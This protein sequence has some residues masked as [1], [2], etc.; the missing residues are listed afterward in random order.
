MRK[1][2]PQRYHQLKIFDN[3]PKDSFGTYQSLF[4]T[5]HY[6]GS[7][8]LPKESTDVND[9]D[10]LPK[11]KPPK[12]QLK[13]ISAAFTGIW[14]NPAQINIYELLLWREKSIANCLI[15][16][17][18]SPLY[19]HIVN[20]RQQAINVIENKY[21]DIILEYLQTLCANSNKR[22]KIFCGNDL[23]MSF[24]KFAHKKSLEDNNLQSPQKP[25]SKDPKKSSAVKKLTR[26]YILNKMILG[27]S[28]TANNNVYKV[29]EF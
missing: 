5:Y 4:G 26:I 12:T 1:A 24:S 16:S 9:Q 3:D 7:Q 25:Q 17:K 27:V 10:N 13:N 6:V 29:N 8:Y 19:T 11:S 20:L 28:A 14:S 23:L 2:R 22:R 15:D 18:Q 21:K